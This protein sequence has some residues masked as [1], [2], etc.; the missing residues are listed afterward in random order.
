MN[1]DRERLS[2]YEQ[3]R[4]MV[5]V[6]RK[7]NYLKET[8]DSTTDD[9]LAELLTTDVEELTEINRKLRG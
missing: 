1:N 4:L 2:T 3:C 8:I 6:D 5:L 9:F 7:L